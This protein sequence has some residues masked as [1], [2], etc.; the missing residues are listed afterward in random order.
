MVSATIPVPVA[1]Q[2]NTIAEITTTPA[3]A[4]QRY[5]RNRIMKLNLRKRKLKQ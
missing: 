5:S 2:N 3:S 1:I 4:T